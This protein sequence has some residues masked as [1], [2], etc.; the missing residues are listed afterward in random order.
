MPQASVNGESQRPSKTRFGNATCRTRLEGWVRMIAT[1]SPIWGRI[2]LKAFCRATGYSREH[3]TRTLSAIRRQSTDLAFETKI[4]QRRKN[5]PKRWGV[6]VAERSRLRFDQYSL[7]YDI[8][9]RWLHNYTDLG[10]G[11]QKIPPTIFSTNGHS[12]HPS[13]TRSDAGGEVKTLNAMNYLTGKPN[14]NTRASSRKITRFSPETPAAIFSGR[15]A[16]CDA[17]PYV[18]GSF[19]TQQSDLY[20]AE[21]G[22]ALSGANDAGRRPGRYS[23]LRRKAFAMLRRLANEHWDN[24]KVTFSH[25]TGFRYVLD[26]LVVGHEE[27]RILDCYGR[28]LFV[29][30][31]LAT[32][33][34]AHTGEIVYFNPSSTVTKARRLLEKN[35]LTAKERVAQWYRKRQKAKET[36][37]LAAPTFTPPVLSSEPLPDDVLELHRKIAESLGC[38]MPDWDALILGP[39]TARISHP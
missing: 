10:S 27:E 3:A 25:R 5:G 8:N 17:P 28:A 12:R 35:G 36:L 30:H 1:R 24:C 32:D 37:S 16:P 34:A 21:R 6:I 13:Q 4:C 9:G 31:G 23:P 18:E 22:V 26:A 2:D 15:Y 11:R 20:G 14:L 7:F 19:G 39:T 38:D 33:I 29:C